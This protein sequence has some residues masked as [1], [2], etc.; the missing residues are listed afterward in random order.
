MSDPRR[1]ASE[2]I[3]A[4]FV[5][6]AAGA[7]VNAAVL[8][9]ND[10]LGEGNTRADIQL[11]VPVVSALALIWAWRLL[12]QIA[13][14]DSDHAAT[15]RSAYIA[16]SV[17]SASYVVTIVNFLWMSPRVT[18][19]SVSTWLDGLGSLVTAMGFSMMARQFPRV[20]ATPD[21]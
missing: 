4:G 20:P 14:A 17:W 6:Q 12:A 7:V 15:Y 19:Y 8:I 10:Y 13:V 9:H 21:D 16:L 3:I 18:E 5:V 1:L 2:W 11:F